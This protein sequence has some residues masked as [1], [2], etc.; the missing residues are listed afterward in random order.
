[1]VPW[2]TVKYDFTRSTAPTTSTSLRW[3][4]VANRHFVSG[5]EKNNRHT[6]NKQQGQSSSMSAIKDLVSK[7]EHEAGSTKSLDKSMDKLRRGGSLERPRSYGHSPTLASSIFQNHE[8]APHKH[9]ESVCGI[10]IITAL[11]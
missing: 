7:F 6:K 3:C 4:P 9:Y 10:H 2:T 11:S 8:D 1:M 5:G